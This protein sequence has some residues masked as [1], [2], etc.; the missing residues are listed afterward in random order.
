MLNKQY[1]NHSLLK[2]FLT[3]QPYFVWNATIPTIDFEEMEEDFSIWE[4]DIE[5]VPLEFADVIKNSYGK[6]NDFFYK[7]IAKQANVLKK[8]ILFINEKNSEIAFKKTMEA[9]SNNEID[10]IVNPVFIF[11][12][13]IAKPILYRKDSKTI[14]SLIH[15]SKSK[16][17]NYIQ[18]YFEIN[19]IQRIIKNKVQNYSF[20]TYDNK[21]HYKDVPNLMFMESEYCWTQK[22]GP[23]KGIKKTIEEVAI[24][25]IFEKINLGIINEKKN[26][27]IAFDR[28]FEW[29]VEQIRQAK[30][31]KT[32]DTINEKDLTHWG[33]NPIFNDIFPFEKLN[34]PKVSGCVLDKNKLLSI[35]NEEEN[36]SNLKSEIK[37]LELILEHKNQINIDE[38]LKSINKIK[39]KKCVWFDFEGFSLP[40]VIFPNTRPYQQ[41]V[42]QVSIIK[43]IEDEIIEKQ[44]IVIDPKSLCINDFKTIVDVIY[45]KEFDKYIV[46]NK[47]YE[48]TKLK[49]I[50]NDIFWYQLNEQDFKIYK[51]K[52]ETIIENTYDLLDLFKQSKSKSKIPI[53]FLHELK[54]FSS[55]KKIENFITT[56]QIN[57]PLMIKPYKSLKVQNGLMAMNKGIQRYLNTI[58]D[59]EWNETKK[60]LAEYCENDVKAMIMVYYFVLYLIDKTKKD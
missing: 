47:D 30:N 50:L 18:A 26:D 3:C 22:N 7:F 54:G 39:N 31:I 20:F 9:F 23:S 42:F 60:E 4:I 11:E 8:K 13:L 1:I 35:L 57:L 53:I 25:T 10:W 33:T 17:I 45:D 34:L 29:Y 2:R 44:N 36:I 58:G 55:I 6:I 5:D 12:D 28:E 56:N 49:E 24:N 41:F 32:F 48:H 37:S 16:L 40:Y 14:S 27:I 19:V 51:A 43:T 59:L 46:Y 52:I 38:V 15:S 21:Y